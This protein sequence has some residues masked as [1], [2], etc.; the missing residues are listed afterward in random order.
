MLNANVCK[1]EVPQNQLQSGP[2]IGFPRPNYAQVAKN[3]LEV[4]IVPLSFKDLSFTN[5]EKELS[6]ILNYARDTYTRTSWGKAKINFTIVPESSAI[7]EEGSFQE[8]QDKNDSNLSIIT[9][10]LLQK[11]EYSK[12][13][14]FNSIVLITPQSN[15]I[16]WGGGNVGATYDSKYGKLGNVYLSIGGNRLVDLPHLLGHT[17]YALSDLYISSQAILEKIKIPENLLFYDLMANGYS[18][19][20]VGFLRW[21]NGW[22]DDNQVTCMNPKQES[23]VVYLRRLDDI[24]GNKLV[25]IP[26]EAGKVVMAE[27]RKGSFDDGEGLLVYSF[28]QNTPPGHG[29]MNQVRFG[30]MAETLLI[31]QQS[32]TLF[33]ITFKVLDVDTN[34]IFVQISR[35]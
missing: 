5:P 6:E 13:A 10:L 14:Q 25:V 16:S 23:S 30:N 21:V 11:I 15:T 27:F 22:M 29:Q 9:Q 8:F 1:V 20:Y 12:L 31:N 33:G 28:D 24:G 19:D 17:L 3:S 35:T 4:L 32:G 26:I 34:G 7:R 2:S 18:K